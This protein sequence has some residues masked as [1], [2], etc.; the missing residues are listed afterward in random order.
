MKKLLII[1][2]SLFLVACGTTIA[3]TPEEALEKFDSKER[4][5]NITKV[6]NTGSYNVKQ[7]FYVFEAEVEDKTKWFVANVVTN[8][9]YFYV[10]ESIDIGVPNS[11]NEANSAEAK[12][13]IAGIS[14]KTEENKNNR[15]IVNIPESDYY[16]WIELL[17]NEK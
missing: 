6:L 4:T 2:L 3:A 5:I 12:T 11:E 16:V 15:I 14:N 8:D 13:F 7:V 17:K 1:L 10:K 9:L